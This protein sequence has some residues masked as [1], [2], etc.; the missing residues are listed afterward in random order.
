MGCSGGGS[1]LATFETLFAYSNNRGVEVSDGGHLHFNEFIL[2]DN[3]DY[4]FVWRQVSTS[5]WGEAL[6][7]QTKKIYYIYCFLIVNNSMIISHSTLYLSSVI[8]EGNANNGIFTPLNSLLEISNT[9]FANFDRYDGFSLVPCAF[10]HFLGGGM[11]VRFSNISFS[12]SSKNIVNFHH[13]HEVNY[14]LTYIIL[15]NN[16]LRLF[17]PIWMVVYPAS[18]QGLFVLLLEYCQNNAKLI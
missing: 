16:F 17:T 11:E 2:A 13:E 4:Q 14:P 10:C 8:S 6:S 15:F 5:S 7:I 9:L 3:R 1:L 12:D 18:Q